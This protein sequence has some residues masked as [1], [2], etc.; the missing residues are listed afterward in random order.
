MCHLRKRKI[1]QIFN[2]FRQAFIFLYHCYIALNNLV[3]ISENPLFATLLGIA[4]DEAVKNSEIMKYIELIA[5]RRELETGIPTTSEEVIGTLLR[6]YDGYQFSENQS[7]KILTP[8]SFLRYLKDAANLEKSTIEEDGSLMLKPYWYSSGTPTPFRYAAERYPLSLFSSLQ[9]PGVHR[10]KK[11][12]L[13][14]SCMPHEYPRYPYIQ[15]FQSGYLTI[16]KYD[17]KTKKYILRFP[18]EEVQH[19]WENGVKSYRDA[20]F[21]STV[22]DFIN[23]RDWKEADLEIQ[24]WLKQHTS[25][26]KDN[27]FFYHNIFFALLRQNMDKEDCCEGQSHAGS[28]VPDVVYGH[29]LDDD[30]CLII[31]IEAKWIGASGD[32]LKGTAVKRNYVYKAQMDVRIKQW[33]GKRKAHYYTLDLVFGERELQSMR[34]YEDGDETKCV[35]KRDSKEARRKLSKV[36]EVVIQKVIRVNEDG[37]QIFNSS[38]P[39]ITLRL[40]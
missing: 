28:S 5:L 3:D 35:Y 16:D 9:V 22:V 4:K 29:L 20:M 14:T 15:L 31:P 19:A 23:K 11:D 17:K 2:I 18:N 32:Q 26:M 30:T 12:T 10:I 37:K 36:G 7:K 38:L 8:Y 13:E 21:K 1:L 27:E 24:N 33:I 34:V 6:Y 39:L 40:S 25:Q